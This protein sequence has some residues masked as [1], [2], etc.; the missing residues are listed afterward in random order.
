MHTNSISAKNQVLKFLYK[1]RKP[2][3]IDQSTVV[4]VQW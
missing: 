2:N 1:W 3:A 4:E